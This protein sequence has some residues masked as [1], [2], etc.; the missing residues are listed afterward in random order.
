MFIRE[1]SPRATY[2]NFDYDTIKCAASVLEYMGKEEIKGVKRMVLEVGD[3]A[4]FGHFHM[5][6]ITRMERLKELTLEAKEGESYGWNTG[7]N[8]RL[9]YALGTMER[10]V[11]GL[12]NDFEGA[13][14]QD[15]GWRCPRVTIVRADNGEKLKVLDCFGPLLEGWKE[16]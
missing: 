11:H 7:R 12:N 3:A 5:E 9:S 13:R 4:Y 8:T 14:H 2:V 10:V 16:G 6:T 15:L 1:P